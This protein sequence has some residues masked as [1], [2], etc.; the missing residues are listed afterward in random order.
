[1]DKKGRFYSCPLLNLNMMK[2]SLLV[3]FFLLATT[4]GFAQ[5]WFGVKSSTPTSF[6]KTLISS[7]EDEIVVG[8]KVDGFNA[9]AVKTDKG[10][11]V[12]I[13]ADDMASMLIKGAPDVPM[14][15]IPM[16]IGDRA[17][18]Q[19]SVIESEY[20]DF[21]G[22]EVAPSKGNFSR[23]INPDDVEYVYGLTSLIKC[24]FYIV[25]RSFFKFVPFD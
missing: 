9:T 12:V 23:Q 2:K 1:M 6:Q 17:E 15:P 21:E 25:I 3:S 11:Q 13:S 14:F 5:E 24:L 19:V 10:E 18:M 7:T 8:V 16:I 20:T 4:F 22:I